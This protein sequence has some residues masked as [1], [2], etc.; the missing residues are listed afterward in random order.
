MVTYLQQAYA[1]SGSF[2]TMNAGF[3]GSFSDERWSLGGGVEHLSTDGANV[4][5][6]GSEKDE[7]DLTTASL[8]ARFA[9]TDSVEF[10]GGLRAVD[11]YSQFDAVD[12]F[13][14]GLPADS[15]VA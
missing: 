1:E 6:T 8:N 15:D 12:F 3:D 2:G 7:S 13:V 14:T 9:A 10:H 5:R 4:S 11:A